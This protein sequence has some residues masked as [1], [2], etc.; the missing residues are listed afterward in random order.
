VGICLASLAA[1]G[2][3]IAVD[4]AMGN[5]EDASS[6]D[7][8]MLAADADAGIEFTGI[9]TQDAT[10]IGAPDT[11][12]SAT[13]AAADWSTDVTCES[14]QPVSECV[15]YFILF[16]SCLHRDAEG[17]WC[18]DSLIPKTDADFTMIEQLCA[19]N[20]QRIQAACP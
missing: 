2:G 13:D 3:R 10:T 12:D 6:P 16:S 17:E 19:V 7:V 11:G 8:S 18:I 15:E 14:G 5:Q 20:L 4:G 9:V 1:C